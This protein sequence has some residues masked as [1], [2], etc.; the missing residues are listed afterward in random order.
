MPKLKGH[1]F[2]ATAMAEPKLD[3]PALSAE[4]NAF[5]LW[6]PRLEYPSALLGVSRGHPGEQERLRRLIRGPHGRPFRHI[7]VAQQDGTGVAEEANGMGITGDFGTNQ[8]HGRGLGEAC[9]LALNIR[10]TDWTNRP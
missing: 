8:H 1:I 5:R 4:L 7:G 6:P 2:V 3:P 9:V 10:G